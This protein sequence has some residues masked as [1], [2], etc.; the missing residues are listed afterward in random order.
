MDFTQIEPNIIV[1]DNTHTIEYVTLG[2]KDIL[3]LDDLKVMAMATNKQRA[4]MCLLQ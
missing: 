1:V 4:C 3:K 2:T